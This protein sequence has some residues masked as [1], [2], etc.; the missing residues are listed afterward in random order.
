MLLFGLSALVLAG[1][2]KKEEEKKVATQVAAK[3][4]SSE[5]TVH[6][7][8][9]LLARVPDLAADAADRA[10]REVLERLIDQ[11]LARQQALAKKLDRTP[12]VQQALEASK[13]EILARAY[14]QLVSGAL[15]APTE[16]EVARYYTAQPELFAQRRIFNLEEISVPAGSDLA[17]LGE[18]VPKARSMQDIADWLTARKIR[19]AAN[20]GV[21]AAEQLPLELLPRLH[22]AKDGEIVVIESGG[23][24]QIVRVMAS[25]AEPVDAATAAP[26]IRQFLSNRAANEAIAKEAK[27]MRDGAKIEY[28]GEFAE[29]RGAEAATRAK[30]QAQAKARSEAKAKEEAEAVAAARTEEATKS[31]RAAEEKA[32]LE[33]EAKE[34]AASGKAPALPQQSVEKGIGGLR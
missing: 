11:E 25:K 12:A 2:G 30:V 15:P 1:C 14:L 5:I 17:G 6:Q 33:S 27:S 29:G 19:F 9:S 18:L 10:K 26:R 16:E 7:V 23:N 8:N 32:R 24:R 21:R 20:R 13:S 31:R 34:R 22:A 28:L 3:V 4:G